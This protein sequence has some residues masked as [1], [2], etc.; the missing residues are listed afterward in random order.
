MSKIFTLITLIPTQIPGIPTLIHCIPIIP[1]LIPHILIVHTLITRI[2]FLIPRIP[3]IPTLI[4]VIP[5]LISRIPI[6]TLILFLDSP[7]QLLQIAYKYFFPL[8]RVFLHSFTAMKQGSW[9][10][11][12]K[13]K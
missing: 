1:T 3:I 12:F 8:R 10:F 9:Q 13:V 4:P 7:F 6:I 11:L 2:A 5:T